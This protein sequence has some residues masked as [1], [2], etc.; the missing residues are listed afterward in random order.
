MSRHSRDKTCTGYE[1]YLL[2]PLLAAS[3]NYEILL[4]IYFLQRNDAN[5]LLPFI[6][7]LSGV[8]YGAAR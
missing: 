6:P 7:R 3:T 4:G 1:H 8:C 5:A 2:A